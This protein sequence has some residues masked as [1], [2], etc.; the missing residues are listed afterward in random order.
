MEMHS[1]DITP[2]I[3]L[4]WFYIMHYSSL[5][6]DVL[7]SLLLLKIP[8]FLCTS[9][10]NFFFLKSSELTH[11]TSEMVPRPSYINYRLK[12]EVSI[13]FIVSYVQPVTQHFESRT[14]QKAPLQSTH[15]ERKK[16]CR[17]ARLYQLSPEK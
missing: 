6:I 11:T 7:W 12:S 1:R 5:F 10:L 9:S 13:A 16:W 3:L 17:A 14:V 2:L 4:L 8:I 15:T